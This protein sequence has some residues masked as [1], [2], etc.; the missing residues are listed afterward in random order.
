MSTI[1]QICNQIHQVDPF[2]YIHSDNVILCVCVCFFIDQDITYVS[3]IFSFS[4]YLS[5]TVYFACSWT[6]YQWD[7]TAL[8]L[9]LVYFIQQHYVCEIYLCKQM[10]QLLL[11]FLLLYNILLHNYTKIYF[12]SKTFDLFP[13]WIY[14]E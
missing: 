14:Y 6:S 13:V 1:T 2:I 4:F 5:T 9:C 11:I 10:Y 12:L 7:H 8:T 3:F